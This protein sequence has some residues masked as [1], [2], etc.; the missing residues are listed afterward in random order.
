MTI[1]DAPQL[2]IV[3]TV[4]ARSC[5]GSGT[6]RL[7]YDLPHDPGLWKV[8]PIK[9]HMTRC[10]NRGAAVGETMYYRNRAAAVCTG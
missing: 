9:H 1:R 2:Q 8:T 4:N 10:A 6:V 5:A 3:A 7:V